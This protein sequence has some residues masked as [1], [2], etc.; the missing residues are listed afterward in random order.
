MTEPTGPPTPADWG[1]EVDEHLA[2]AHDHIDIAQEA[3]DRTRVTQD[4][5]QVATD[6]T[7]VTTHRDQVAADRD[8]AMTDRTQATTDR[9]Q[10]ATDR[11]QATIDRNQA[12][13]DR[14]QATTDRDQATTDRTQATTDRD[15]ADTDRDQ[16]REMD[17]TSREEVVALA[18][19]V[20]EL[21]VSVAGLHDL[22]LH[23]LQ[24]ADQAVADAAAKPS[25]KGV[26]GIATAL[27]VFA[28]ILA[29]TGA[30]VVHQGQNRA[31]AACMERNAAQADSD[32]HLAQIDQ[33]V[34]VSRSGSLLARNLGHLLTPAARHTINCR[35]LQP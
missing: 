15:Q 7:R 14:T 33:A 30:Y 34:Q 3:T 11:T 21:A 9:D 31:Y 26:Y 12:T 29:G 4:R 18:K 6:R 8:Q 16:H 23:S 25:R 32:A 17:R 20:A 28:L 5:D 1:A 19:A 35:R 24:K 2:E 10:V 27:A 22:I 13:T